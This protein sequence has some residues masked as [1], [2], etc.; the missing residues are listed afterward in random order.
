MTENNFSGLFRR[1]VDFDLTSDQTQFLEALGRY[2]EEPAAR[3]VFIVK[4]FAGTGKTSML[5]ALV[6]VLR[7]LRRRTLLMAPTGR[8]AKVFA[9][10]SGS[11]AYTIHKVIYRQK[12]SN[13]APGRFALD[14]NLLSDTLFIVDE[15]SMIANSPAD[16]SIFGSGRLLDDM[17]EYVFGGRQCKLILA[18]DTAQLPPVGSELSP[19]LDADEFRS[20]GY[21]VTEV[22]LRMVVRQN[23]ES[24]IL[25]NATLLRNLMQEEPVPFPQ[26]RTAPYSDVVRL[27]GSEF[28]EC[29]T[30]AYSRYGK[31]EVMVV[32]RTNKRANL[33]NEGIRGRI[34]FHE[35]EICAGDRVMIVK[36]NY[37]WITENEKLNFLA[38]GD[39][40]TLRRIGKYE[41]RYGYRFLNVDLEL[42]DY[43]DYELSCKVMLNTLSMETPSL[44]AEQSKEFFYAVAEDYAH[45]HGP[46]RWKAVREDPFYSAV[47]IK[48]A[49]AVTCHKAQG[50][51]W[52]AVFVDQGWFADD[53]LGREYLRWLYTAVT[54]P[55][56]Q[57]Y[58][59][60]F[61]P[62]FLEL[63]GQE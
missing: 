48:F 21:R 44:T 46:D 52:R 39:I 47:Q 10:Y 4:G 12:S 15:A 29:L 31:E 16:S 51:Q 27:P 3:S 23:A 13:Q 24:K 55:V 7:K 34:F 1:E 60:N 32:C 61:D 5:S 43:G 54:R 41:E 26:F 33:F 45:L 35:E 58:L 38:N 18:G 57:L 22:Q 20:M 40:A 2:M 49:Y 14:R 8:A 50:G 6:R 17:L 37:H 9:G 62:R 56:E 30:D 42:P 19:A 63:S 53:M 11:A 28:V 36:N 59:V 25:S